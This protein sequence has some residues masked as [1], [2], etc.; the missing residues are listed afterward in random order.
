M[1][2]NGKAHL[3]KALRVSRRQKFSLGQ[4][5]DPLWVLVK[6]KEDLRQNKVKMLLEG[7]W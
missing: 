5:Q 7:M 4:F 6:H 1:E 2:K 3:W